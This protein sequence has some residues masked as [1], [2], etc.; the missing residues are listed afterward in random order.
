M[1]VDWINMRNM[2]FRIL[3]NN[4]TEILANE[5]IIM[6]WKYDDINVDQSEYNLSL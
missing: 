3:L 6:S 2:E 4:K 5:I 1:K